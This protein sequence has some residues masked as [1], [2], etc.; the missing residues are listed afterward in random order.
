MVSAKEFHLV[1]A[2]YLGHRFKINHQT[3]NIVGHQLVDLKLVVD[4]ERIDGVLHW[5]LRVG[6]VYNLV[7]TS[8]KTPMVEVCDLSEMPTSKGE[9][10]NFKMS[11]RA[12]ESTAPPIY[13]ISA[14]NILWK[15]KGLSKISKFVKRF[16]DICGSI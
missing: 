1:S 3:F 4:S 12:V 10:Y 14:S 7:K 9:G 5:S 13:R 2:T 15:V 16:L 6:D 11:E 8:S